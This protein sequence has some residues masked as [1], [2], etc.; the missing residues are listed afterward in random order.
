MANG[1]HIPQVFEGHSTPAAGM[2]SYGFLPAAHHS[3]DPL[4]REILE[5]KLVSQA[6]EIEQLVTDNHTLASTHV[7]LK[8]DISAVHE[9]IEKLRDHVRSIRTE[10]DI[11]IR[12]TLDKMAKKESAVQASDSIK[13]DLQQSINEAQNLVTITQELDAKFK[14]ATEELEKTRL[15]FKKL[16]EVR[17]ELE[18]LQQEHQQLRETFEFEKGKNVAK[19][20]QMKLLE[21]DVVAKATEVE[22]LRTELLNAERRAKEMAEFGDDAAPLPPPA[23]ISLGKKKPKAKPTGSKEVPLAR[24]IG[25]STITTGEGFVVE[26]SDV[27]VNRV[28]VARGK[29]KVP[30][31]GMTEVGGIKR[32]REQRSPSPSAGW[33][34]DESSILGRIGNAGPVREDQGKMTP[35]QVAERIGHDLAEIS[36]AAQLLQGRAMLADEADRYKK[37]AAR[38]LQEVKDIQA[39]LEKV[40]K[41]LKKSEEDRVLTEKVAQRAIGEAAELKARL[42]N[43]NELA[44]SVFKDNETGSAFLTA[45]RRTKIGEDLILSFGRW[46]FKAGQRKMLERAQKR[47]E[48]ALEGDDL[49]L[50]LSALP[51]DLADPGPSPFAPKHKAADPSGPAATVPSEAEACKKEEAKGAKK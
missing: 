17:S 38:R 29:E 6:A 4:H 49:Q 20:E 9:E 48:Q 27:L 2:T 28:E 14:P 41:D 25:T 44:K 51:P 16:P 50:V 36:R 32:R 43:P 24:P 18:N 30:E 26:P 46:A 39:E 11:Q 33:N 35:T 34:K 19:V 7:T 12:V 21:T 31:K 47:M 1:R 37:I 40:Q 15:E 45:A 13:N 22:R 3:V 42:E 23:K 8:Q 10:S 5:G